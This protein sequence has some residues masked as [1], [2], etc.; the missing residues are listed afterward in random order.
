[1]MRDAVG[2]PALVSIRAFAGLAMVGRDEPAGN[3]DPSEV[4]EFVAAARR[5]DENAVSQSMRQRS[6]AF[7]GLTLRSGAE[8]RRWNCHHPPT[9]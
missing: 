6:G 7:S 2:I 8:R 1:M 4:R 9:I 5:G 3:Q